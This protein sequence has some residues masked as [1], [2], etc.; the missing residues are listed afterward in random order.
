MKKINLD[1]KRKTK[2]VQ[3]S[4]KFPNPVDVEFL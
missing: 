1:M 3:L 4:E 2:D